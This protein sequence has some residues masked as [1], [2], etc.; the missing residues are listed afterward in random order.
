MT[1][2]RMIFL[3]GLMEQHEKKLPGCSGRIWRSNPSIS[4][5]RPT[6]CRGPAFAVIPATP[7]QPKTWSGALSRRCRRMLETVS[8]SHRGNS[9][10]SSLWRG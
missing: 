3:I 2:G 9:W 8:V 10:T 5:R 6:S 1:L 4:G 7:L